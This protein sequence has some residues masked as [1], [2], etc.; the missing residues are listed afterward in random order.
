MNKTTLN[1]IALLGCATA[2]AQFSTGV[3]NGT[4]TGGTNLNMTAKIDVSA[5]EVTLTLTGN[6]TDWLGVGLGASGMD[7]GDC[8]IFDGT[9]LSDRSFG[10]VGVTPA[11]DATQSWTVT[12]NTVN[13]GVRTVIGT[14]ALNTG[15]P[16]DY[17]FANA[18]GP[19]TLV[20]ARRAGSMTIG[21]H[22]NNSCGTTIANLAL[23]SEDFSAEKVKMYPN[24]AKANVSFQLPSFVTSG[25]IKIYDAQGR[26]VKRQEISEM[27]TNVSLA[28]IPTGTYMAVVRTQHGNAT[29]TLIVE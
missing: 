28:G 1:L 22:G 13:S 17:V 11:L 3:L 29:K 24:P 19:L 23:S 5:T 25:E 4:S 6:S 16:N 10:G 21:Y 20:F 8:V 14:R 2:M 9:N 15:E 7:S 27:E 12:S 26:M 18:A